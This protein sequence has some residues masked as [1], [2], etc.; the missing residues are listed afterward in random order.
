GKTLCARARKVESRGPSM[1]PCHAQ[2]CFQSAGV[3][4]AEFFKNSAR[5]FKGQVVVPPCPDTSNG[6]IRVL[7]SPYF[8]WFPWAHN[9]K[10]GGSNPPPV[11]VKSMECGPESLSS[12]R[13]TR[14]R[15]VNS[16]P[17]VSAQKLGHV[18]GHVVCRRCSK[19]DIALRVSHCKVMRS[20]PYNP[21]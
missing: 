16:E 2:D 18:L 4:R 7:L 19:Y 11:I 21:A 15:L 17:G 8:P 1:R 13:P 3:S 12:P 5:N 14:N 20:Q 9:P 6:A 10:V